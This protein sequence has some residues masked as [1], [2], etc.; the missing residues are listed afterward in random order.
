MSSKNITII[1]IIVIIILAGFYLVRKSSK[2]AAPNV[3]NTQVS[4]EN[5][6][7]TPEASSSAAHGTVSVTES[8]DGFSPASVTIKAGQTVTWTNSDSASHTVNSNPHP[9][10]TD[11]PPL[12]NV[13]LIA[14]GTGKSFTFN[15]PGTYHYHDHLNPSH[16]GTVVVQ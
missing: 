5:A 1:V 10:H 12:N 11:Y 4:Q 8:A 2:T 13:G 3:T 9:T 7:A 15:T 16:Q 14:P 6:S